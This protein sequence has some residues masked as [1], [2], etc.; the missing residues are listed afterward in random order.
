M[1]NFEFQGVVYKNVEGLSTVYLKPQA[2][3]TI[4]GDQ[5]LKAVNELLTDMLANVNCSIPGKTE[6]EAWRL[7]EEFKS[8]VIHYEQ[9]RGDAE[10]WENLVHLIRQYSFHIKE[11]KDATPRLTDLAT[12][13]AR[14][15]VSWA[16]TTDL[17][18]DWIRLDQYFNAAND[19]RIT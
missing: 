17:R 13:V 9:L 7:A 2:Q 11:Y 12:S 16:N 14:Y 3:Y 10:Y 6:D 15:I 18:K 8:D 19:H 4:N 5:M 1:R